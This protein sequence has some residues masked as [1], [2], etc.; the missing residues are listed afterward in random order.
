MLFSLDGDLPAEYEAVIARITELRERLRFYTSDHLNRWTRLMARTTA[1]RVIVGTNAMEGVNV[2]QE[3]AI[4]VVDGEEALS[5]EDEDK[6]AIEGY[7]RAMTY[8]VQLSK[9][10]GHEHNEGTIKSFQYM[11]LGHDLTKHPGRYR[12]GAIHVT[13]TLTNEVVYHAPDV[14]MVRPLMGEL[15]NYLNTSTQQYLVKA[16]MAH[17]NLTMIHPF[18]D[19]NGRMARALQTMV[20]SREGIL[21]P[22]FSSIEEYIGRHSSDYYEVLAQVGQG[23]WNPKNDPLP[24]IRFS[25]TAHYRQATDLLRRTT[26]LSRLWNELEALVNTLGINER[27]V[28][29]LADAALGYKVKNPTYRQQ[30]EVSQQTAKTDLRALV[31]ANLLV[32]KGETRARYY[33]AGPAVVAIRKQTKSKRIEIDPFE[34]LTPHVQPN[35]PGF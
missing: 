14:E 18:S 3:E 5:A 35:L 20:L 16:A 15:V 1:A 7:W 32:P 4:A 28:N 25:L 23:Q 8:I 34:D 11:M 10:E 2:T 26:D 22:N 24:W 6:H 31:D 19:G 12:P 27:C 29:A 21:D 9:E 30:A 33:V 17:L 13:N